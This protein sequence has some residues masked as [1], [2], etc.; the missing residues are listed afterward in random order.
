MNTAD[1]TRLPELWRRARN[2]L[3]LIAVTVVMVQDHAPW[4]LVVIGGLGWALL[5]LRVLP[6]RPHLVAVCVTLASGLALTALGARGVAPVYLV[7]ALAGSAAVLDLITTGVLA[8][9]GLLALAAT[10]ATHHADLSSIA[11]WCGVLIAVTLLVLLRRQREASAEQERL[12]ADEQALAAML[13]E[14]ARL[15]REIHDVLAHS[16]SALSV[17]L[18]TAAALLERDRTTE[19]AALIDRA[20]TLARDGLTET[21]RAVSALRG[22]P[23]PVPELVAELTAGYARDLGAPATFTVGGEP[24]ELDPET[25]LALFRAA[26]EA[27]SNVRKHAPGSAVDAHLAF[28]AGAVALRV[29]NHGPAG[30][31]VTGLSSGYGLI[32][33]RE[34][35][36]MAGGSVTVGPDSDGWLVDVRMPG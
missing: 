22:D 16:L 10:L 23:L 7:V 9:I 3:V 2:L 21:R 24:R 15:A 29:R 33:L 35:A 30:P 27:L 34:R 32:G 11:V 14:R 6:P 5:T 8:G 1:R 31:P 13:A 19:A 17:Q 4:P 25:G 18:E 20:G 12:L 36:E 26:Q 28:E